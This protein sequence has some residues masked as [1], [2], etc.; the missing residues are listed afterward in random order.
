MIGRNNIKFVL[1]LSHISNKRI[2]TQ[3]FLSEELLV[4][5]SCSKG[6]SSLFEGMTSL[7]ETNH[8]VIRIFI[9]A[10]VFGLLNGVK[11]SHKDKA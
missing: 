10:Q 5:S 8:F 7:E 11:D 2:I 6:N 9:L 3:L 1:K 4:Q